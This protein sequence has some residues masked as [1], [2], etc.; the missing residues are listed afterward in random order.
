M[1]ARLSHNIS[2]MLLSRLA[3]HGFAVLFNVLL[4][5]RLGSAG[6]GEYASLAVI[7]LIANALTTFGTD[8]LLIRE[9]A[10]SGVSARLQ[11]ALKL[12][13]ALSAASIA[14]IWLFGRLL[15]G[16]SAEGLL[17]LR[18]YSLALIPL[19]FFTVFTTAL[20][21]GERMGA[22]M[23][24]NLALAAGQMAVFV[25]P[26]TELV[27]L[28]ILL[29][30]IQVGGALLA[31]VLCSLRLPQFWLRWRRGSA[32]I[33]SL[34]HDTA[35]LAGLAVLTI[36]YQRLNVLMLLAMAG[37]VSTGLYSAAARVVE[38]FRLLQ[39]AAF[40]ALY[41]VMAQ[42]A[43]LR[44]GAEPRL[45]SRYVRLLLAAALAAA[46][47]L[48]VLA[49]PLVRL[50]YGVGYAASGGVA[51]LLAW[52][53]IPFTANTYLSLHLLASRREPTAARGLMLAL[54]GLLAIG[55]WRIPIEGA[56]GAAWAVLGA[57]ALQSILLLISLRGSI[58]LGGRARELPQS[59]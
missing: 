11:A 55:L 47:A 56:R 24:L 9:V 43:A 25:L 36:L 38:P 42:E 44:T 51:G 29:L 39:A 13:L 40:T 6:F 50:L 26:H 46:F 14:L 57:E 49:A 22:F 23:L 18:I 54:L 35:P 17:A 1:H 5:R 58:P 34:L 41:P 2:W 21:G 52:S 3:A 27:P 8:M 32:S 12:Q 53:L 59:P 37:P 48:A 20:R 4:A 31:G 45:T 10:V 33:L 19:A 16:L 30:V 15:P 28:A 7:L